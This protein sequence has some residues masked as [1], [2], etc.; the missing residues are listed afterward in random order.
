MVK[1][2]CDF[3]FGSHYVEN[4][5]SDENRESAEIINYAITPHLEGKNILIIPDIITKQ[6]NDVFKDRELVLSTLYDLADTPPLVSSDVV[7]TLIKIASILKIS[8][9]KTFIVT[10]DSYVK[11]RIKLQGD[12][13]NVITIKEALDFLRK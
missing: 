3:S 7:D 10:D 2:I 11:N 13:I 9:E 8:D 4:F 5:Y 1:L 6:L 12:N